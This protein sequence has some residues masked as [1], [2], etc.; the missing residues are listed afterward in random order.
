MASLSFAV[1]RRKLLLVAPAAPTPRELKRLSD[2]DDQEGLRFQIPVI[3]FYRYDPSKE[4]RDPAT[5]IRDAIA[6]A[7]VFYYPFAG[8]LREGPDRKLFVDCTGEG[9]LF[10]EA[11]ADVSIQQFGNALQPPFPCLDQLLFDVEGSSPVLDA[12]LLLI[13]VTLLRC[14]GF[15][16]AMRLNHT[17]ADAQ[18]LVQFMHAVGEL[19]RGAAEPSVLPVWRRELLEARSIPKPTFAH[20]EYDEV[21]DTNGTITPLDD[22]VHRSFFFGAQEVAALR[23]H[24]PPHL[25]RSSTFEILTAFL[26]RSRTLAMQPDPEEEFRIISIVNGRGGRFEQPLPDGYYGNAFAFP[27]A[28]ETARELCG[29]PLAHAV[30]LVKRAKAEV[31]WE[32]LRSLADLMVLRRRPH[33]TVVRTY[34]VSDVTRAGFGDVD[35]GWGKAMYG[36]P[37]KGGVGAI[38]GVASF[39]VPFTNSRGQKGIIVPVCLPAPAME[40]FSLEIE[41]I[42]K[43][44]N[45]QQKVKS[46]L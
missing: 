24:L 39:F 43:A 9:I 17:M 3:Q 26:W 13:Q 28:V 33:F 38:P 7:L 35:F 21:P 8:R 32:Y 31:S 37:A 18:G 45:E 20:R 40:L 36:G 25:R 6:R 44:T 10:I 19:A 42:V 23:S 2:I 41:R 27:V 12:P 30:E 22:M 16:F 1:Q 34:L 5:T 29:R 15:I 46:S 14:G 11:Y 4:G